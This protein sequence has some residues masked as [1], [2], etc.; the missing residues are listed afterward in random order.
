MLSY[1]DQTHNT[2]HGKQTH[3]AFGREHIEFI[4]GPYNT[5]ENTDYCGDEGFYLTP[6]NYKLFIEG[7]RH[8]RNDRRIVYMYKL[9]SLASVYIGPGDYFRLGRDLEQYKQVTD[10]DYYV[11]GEH[12]NSEWYITAIKPEGGKLDNKTIVK[13]GTICNPWEYRRKLIEIDGYIELSHT[14]NGIPMQR[15]R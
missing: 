9:E 13:E 14:P 1:E 2:L 4:T 3:D 5:T 6:E 12:G 8:V 10:D 7:Y 11:S 15:R